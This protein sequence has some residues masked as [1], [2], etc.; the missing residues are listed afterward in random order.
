MSGRKVAAFSGDV[1][2]ALQL[3]A[4][5]AERKRSVLVRNAEERVRWHNFQARA[6]QLKA[7][8]ISIISTAPSSSQ[9]EDPAEPL[10]E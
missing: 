3:C 2:Q 8:R 10:G 7:R 1:R 9:V 5:A 6:E 4:R